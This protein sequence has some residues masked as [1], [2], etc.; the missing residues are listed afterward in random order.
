VAYQERLSEML[1]LG[2]RL[3]YATGTGVATGSVVDMRQAHRA[4]AYFLGG[5]TVGTATLMVQASSQAAFGGGPVVIGVASAGTANNTVLSVAVSGEDVQSARAAEDRWI[6]A[7]VI[8]TGA[9]NGEAFI[10]T[11]CDRYKP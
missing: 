2:G 8:R 10:L 1:V 3:A 11:D 5:A 6:R 4:I 9:T 7:V